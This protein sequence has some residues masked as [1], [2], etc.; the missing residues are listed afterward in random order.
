MEET[1]AVHRIFEIVDC[2]ALCKNIRTD[3]LIIQAN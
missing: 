1:T 3:T 2:Q